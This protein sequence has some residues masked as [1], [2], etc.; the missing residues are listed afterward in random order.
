[1]EVC[2]KRGQTLTKFLAEIPNKSSG[3]GQTI[4]SA[5]KCNYAWLVRQPYIFTIKVTIHI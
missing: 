4:M 3:L 2:S 5:N 1:M